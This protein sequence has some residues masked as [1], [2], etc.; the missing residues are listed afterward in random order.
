MERLAVHVAN[1]APSPVIAVRVAVPEALAVLGVDAP[2]GWTARFV[3]ASDSSPQ[4]IEWTG[5][6][7]AQREYREFAFF[8]RLDPNARE[9]PLVLPVEVRHAD[10]ARVRWRDGGNAPAPVVLVRGT[11]SASA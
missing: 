8:A 1:P 3:A 10:G 9:Q 5:G 4:A 2:A 11:V 7:L 6:A